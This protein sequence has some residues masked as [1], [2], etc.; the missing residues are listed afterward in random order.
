[1]PSIF[2]Q[3]MNRVTTLL[4]QG[5]L[6]PSEIALDVGV[7]EVDVYAKVEERLLQRAVL[8]RAV[9]HEVRELDGG[10]YSYHRAKVALGLLEKWLWENVGYSYPSITDKEIADAPLACKNLV[11]EIQS[12]VNVCRALSL[13]GTADSAADAASDD[14]ALR[15]SLSAYWSTHRRA[16]GR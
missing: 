12:G 15:E 10:S 6:T 5:R 13:H 9:C 16:S 8:I 4:R 7:S 2:D 11:D 1:M 3:Q 14:A